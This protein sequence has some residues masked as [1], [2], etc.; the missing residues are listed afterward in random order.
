MNPFLRAY[1]AIRKSGW[2]VP[3][4]TS[5][6]L[7]FPFT[8]QAWTMLGAFVAGIV[9]TAFLPADL[10]WVCRISLCVAYVGLGMIS[11]DGR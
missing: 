3:S 7:P 6:L 9:A 2:F 4:P 10:A 8:W 11:Y 1:L 5:G